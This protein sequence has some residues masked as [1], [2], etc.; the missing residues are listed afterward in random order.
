MIK[1]QSTCNLLLLLI[2]LLFFSCN[3]LSEKGIKK[4]KLE[5]SDS[6]SA[7]K[8]VV[9]TLKSDVHSA[10]D[11]I[12]KYNLD[13]VNERCID[14]IYMIYGPTFINGGDSNTKMSIGECNIQLIG[15]RGMNNYRTLVYGIFVSDSIP[16]EWIYHK[17]IPRLTDAFEI[18]LPDKKIVEVKLGALGKVSIQNVEA[19]YMNSIK[20]KSTIEYLHNNISIIHPNFKKNAIRLGLLTN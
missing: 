6:L 2:I 16:Y 13:S 9:S 15:F 1:K 7:L 18:S 12:K 4:T 19:E 10:L 20:S 17:R 3:D 5:E 8:K 11:S 14:Y